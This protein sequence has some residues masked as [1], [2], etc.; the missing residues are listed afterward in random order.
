MIR[1]TETAT[2]QNARTK[3]LDSALNL[4]RQKGYCATSV[5]DLCSAAGVTKGAFFHHFKSKDELAVAA[6]GH[7]SKI[8]SAFFADAPYHAAFDPLE[9]V[10]GYIKFRK[11]IMRGSVPEFTCLVGTMVQETYASYPAI[12][13]A[14]DASISDHAAS[15]EHDIEE[16][17]E[18]AT[19]E[20]GIDF[21]CTAQSLA[22]HT[23][24]V[25]Q[26]AFVLAKARGGPEIAIDSVN[27]LISYVRLL[28]GLPVQPR[29]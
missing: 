16:A 17:M 4:I 14:C 7:W 10:F 3:L 24:S 8:T 5:D 2:K 27:H 6:A 13:Q 28:F 23:Q 21:D 25:L 1:M 22:L 26:G 12:R 20:R 29:H 15:L 19:Q 11:E 9:R 18:R